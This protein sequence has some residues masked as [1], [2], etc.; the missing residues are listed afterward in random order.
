MINYH[1]HSRQRHYILALFCIYILSQLYHVCKC[2]AGAN[3]AGVSPLNFWQQKQAVF[4]ELASIARLLLAA[5]ASLVHV[6]RCFSASGFLSSDTRNRMDKSLQMGS[7]MKL[8]ELTTDH[9]C[10]FVTSVVSS[11]CSEKTKS[12]F[13]CAVLTTLYAM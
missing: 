11:D 3:F 10:N 4:D 7:Q 2:H 9:F 5:T 8:V 13:C 6:E 1:G 12:L